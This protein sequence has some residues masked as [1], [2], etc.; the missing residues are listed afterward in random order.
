[1]STSDRST[2]R[3]PEPSASPQV[4]GHVRQGRRNDCPSAPKRLVPDRDRPAGRRRPAAASDL[5]STQT[6]VIGSLARLRLVRTSQLQRLHFAKRTSLAAARGAR[7]CLVRLS[8][9]GLVRSLERRVGG[10]SGGSTEAVWA[11]DTAGQH[12]ATGAGPAG[13]S[14]K[15]RPWTPS[16]PFV[17]HRLAITE[18][19]VQLVEGQR[20]GEG[21]L[22]SFLAEPACWR[23][24][25]SASGAAVTL[26]P[27]AAAIT[28][29][30][31]YENAWF[32]EIDLATESPL[33]IGRKTA[34]YLAYYRSGQEEAQSG[35]FPLVAFVVPHKR[36]A[37]VID[38]VIRRL[39]AGDQALFRTMLANEAAGRL[40]RGDA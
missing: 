1:M 38:G 15:R 21:E 34:A 3:S 25:T 22:V 33:V 7:R 23:T 31:D 12:L 2:P 39:P 26:K 4:T 24:Y 9:L 27:D 28:A 35:I 11:L 14:T 32:L 30:G 37:Q 8:E 19:D 36:R 5:T 18:L 20:R 29:Y 10:A 40:L 16:L 17:M 13:G 6:E